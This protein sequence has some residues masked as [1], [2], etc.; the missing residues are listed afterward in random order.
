MKPFVD[1]H[2]KEK[3]K[4]EAAARGD[5]KSRSYY[6]PKPKQTGLM[7]HGDPNAVNWLKVVIWGGVGLLLLC[8]ICTPQDV[9]QDIRDIKRMRQE[10]Y[11]HEQQRDMD[12]LLHNIRTMPDEQKR[13]INRRIHDLG[14][15]DE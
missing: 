9:E 10:R 1:P 13:D 14:P 15:I 3:W 5:A 11:N 12:K 8:M 4:M 2:L 7:P 6:N